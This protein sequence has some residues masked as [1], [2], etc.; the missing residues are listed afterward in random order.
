MRGE[1]ISVDRLAIQNNARR[2]GSSVPLYQYERYC[3]V[4]LLA[5]RA[6]SS[7]RRRPTVPEITRNFI[8]NVELYQYDIRDHTA[9]EKA[10]K[11]AGGEE[12]RG[13]L[14]EKL[15][16][17]NYHDTGVSDDFTTPPTQPMR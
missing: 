9:H 15:R 17:G 10:K 11:C 12:S 13:V 8:R 1:M 5:H 14:K 3:V 4:A 7:S 16:T 2:K 6:L